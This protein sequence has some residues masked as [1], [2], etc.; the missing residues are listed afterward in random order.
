MTEHIG[1]ATV[2]DAM[3][4]AGIP[5]DAAG[6]HDYPLIGLGVASIP[7][8]E[9]ADAYATLCGGGM[10]AQQHIVELVDGPNGGRVPI[11]KTE[12]DDSPAF[13]APVLSDVL[14]AM[15]NVVTNGTGQRARALG[16]PVAGKTGTHQDLTAWF[17]GCTPQIAASV[18]YFKGDGTESLDGAGGLATFFGANFPTQTWTTFMKGA[19]AGKPALDFDIGP[20]VQGSA[21]TL[22]PAAVPVPTVAPTAAPTGPPAVLFPPLQFGGAIPPPSTPTATPA[23][24]PPPAPA[25]SSVATPAQPAAPPAQPQQGQ[26][27]QGQSQPTKPQPAQTAPAQPEPAPAQ[28]TRPEPARTEPANTQPAQTRAADPAAVQQPARAPNVAANASR[29]APPG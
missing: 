2:H 20:G 18:V 15:E 26:P 24:T 13:D 3:A 7:A 11:R 16:R 12:V 1:P 10:H 25:P 4:R 9:V 14:R 23:T 8:T 28:P 29:T 6:L 27:Q 19:L 22:A 5:R 17:N 21:P